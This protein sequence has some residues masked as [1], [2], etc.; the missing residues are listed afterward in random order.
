MGGRWN[1]SKPG[2][3]RPG[4]D[5][6]TQLCDMHDPEAVEAL[7]CSVEGAAENQYVVEGVYSAN[8][9]PH[10]AAAAAS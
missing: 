9:G 3:Q 7:L 1:G 4:S 8:V 6:Q 10:V 2:A 5:T